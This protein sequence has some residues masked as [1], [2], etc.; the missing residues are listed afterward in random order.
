M[1]DDPWRKLGN[2]DINPFK[3]SQGGSNA[4]LINTTEIINTVKTA[5][6]WGRT[7]AANRVRAQL[8]RQGYDPITADAAAEAVKQGR[9]PAA[10]IA[11]ADQ[12][13]QARQ[14]QA[15]MKA[16][17]PPI[18]G[19]ARWAN[20]DDL[21]AANLVRTREPG[22]GPGL[23]LGHAHDQ[24]LYWNGESHL[25]TV[26]PTR[27]GKATMQI[28]PNL[29][30]YQ[31]SA[32]V[33]DP[34]GEL[35]SAT[36]AWRQKHVGPVYLLNP[37]D[38]PP[39]DLPAARYNP[40]DF[41]RDERDATKLAEMIYPRVQ[42]DRHRFFDNEAIGFLTAAVYFLARYAPAAHRT[43]GTLRRAVSG[44]NAEFYGMVRAMTDPAMP[45]SIRNAANNAL[46]KNTDTGLP[47]LIDSLNQHLRI[48]DTPGL[49]NAT[50][51]SD[52][53]FRELKDQAATVYLLLP[54]DELTT[55][56]TFVQLIFAAALDGMLMN[57]RR[58]DTPVLFVLDEF[59]A[60]E[61]DDRFVNALRTH[62]SAGARPWF[63][64]QDLPTLEQKYPTTWKSF[65]QVETKTFF[66]TDD[67]YT[68]EL[69]A[70]YL[71]DR[72]VAYES[73]S[74]GPSVA[75]GG[76]SYSITENLQLTGRPL[77][78]PGEVI[79]RLASHDARQ[80]RQ[81]IHFLRGVPPVA[82]TLTPWFKDP[83]ATARMREADDG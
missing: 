46:S 61:P 1:D 15:A 17:P 80:P 7:I 14:R 13:R 77:L 75:G 62:A 66:G 9:D 19:S 29:L 28:I 18:H 22:T 72:T 27:T 58:P 50:A 4:P 6:A 42:D 12:A 3:P 35:A 70:T 57:P 31:G 68:A 76:A 20:A 38:L 74:G 52:F 59:L 16:N 79:Q 81:A 53:D 71:G 47:R 5:G 56:S 83:L 34:K 10:V 33:L 30:R 32:V 21:T 37:F 69:I 41:V 26:A 65:L 49:V 11:A 54:F 25:L 23:L 48:W 40:L 8:K 67:P 45:D 2:M 39:Y 73:A 44:L 36:A 63:F 82:A 43:F 55:F 64:L 51:T 24:H 78:T 60:L